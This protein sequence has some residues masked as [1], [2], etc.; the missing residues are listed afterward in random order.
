M[1][2]MNTFLTMANSMFAV[3]VVMLLMVASPT[4]AQITAPIDGVIVLEEV[5]EDSYVN[6]GTLLVAIE[7]T[8]AVEVKCSLRMDEL[9][10]LWCQA[11][12]GEERSSGSGRRPFR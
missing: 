2:K 12:S 8:S 11:F 6:K 9:Y 10:W 5:E 3:M 4:Y 7:D 1:K